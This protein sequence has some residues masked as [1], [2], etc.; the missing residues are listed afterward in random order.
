MVI[1]DNKSNNYQI[2]HLNLTFSLVNHL[3]SEH[4]TLFSEK[5]Y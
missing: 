3:G 4:Y 5:G 2:S 1:R